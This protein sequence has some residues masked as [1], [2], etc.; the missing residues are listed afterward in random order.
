MSELEMQIAGLI[1]F[2][3]LIISLIICLNSMWDI[4]CGRKSTLQCI[5]TT[6]QRKFATQSRSCPV[7][8]LVAADVPE[9]R[10]VLFVSI[11]ELISGI[12]S[13]Y[14]NNRYRMGANNIFYYGVNH[15]EYGQRCL[16]YQFILDN[17]GTNENTAA[18]DIWWSRDLSGA[19]KNTA[20]D[21]IR[22]QEADML[23]IRL[24]DQERG[25]Q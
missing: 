16:L 12:N 20:E 1:L 5:T 21:K 7:P 18:Q 14:Q 17:Y 23:C 13:Y 8:K 11:L 6:L 22:P 10:N 2:G 24:W 15:L 4:A 19:R 3:V 9:L 25:N